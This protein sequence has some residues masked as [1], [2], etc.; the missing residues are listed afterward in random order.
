MLKLIGCEKYILSKVRIIRLKLP[1]LIS[2]KLD[3]KVK[4]IIRDKNN[5]GRCKFINMYDSKAT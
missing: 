2:D 4:S 3:F 1:I 5:K